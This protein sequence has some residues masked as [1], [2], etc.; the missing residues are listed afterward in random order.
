VNKR[1]FT[2]EEKVR[3]IKEASKKGVKVILEKY[4]LFSATFYS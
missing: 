1:T 2:V 4:G 3:I